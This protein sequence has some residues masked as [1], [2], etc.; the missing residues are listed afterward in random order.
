M[1]S[2]LQEPGK[3]GKEERMINGRRGGS[4]GDGQWGGAGGAAIDLFCNLLV[5]FLSMNFVHVSIM[6]Q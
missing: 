5:R 1:I 2:I 3:Y 4:W 6:S